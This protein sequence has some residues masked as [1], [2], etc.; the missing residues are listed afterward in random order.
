MDLRVLVDHHDTLLRAHG[1]PFPAAATPSV[2]A[3]TETPAPAPLCHPMT[4]GH[5]VE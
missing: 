4:A 1:I 2:A 5:D 3:P